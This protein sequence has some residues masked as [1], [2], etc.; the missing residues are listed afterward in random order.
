MKLSD[1]VTAERRQCLLVTIY[2]CAPN[3]Y[4]PA[5]TSYKVSFSASASSMVPKWHWIC[6]GSA[7][8]RVPENW[9]VY[10]KCSWNCLERFRHYINRMSTTFCAYSPAW[11]KA[12]SIQDRYGL[13]QRMQFTDHVQL[14]TTPTSAHVVNVRDSGLYSV[15]RGVHNWVCHLEDNDCDIFLIVHNSRCVLRVALAHLLLPVLAA[16]ADCACWPQ[17]TN[18]LWKRCIQTNYIHVSQRHSS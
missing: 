13:L 8:F 15:V 3:I 6:C 7:G 4:R 2:L 14:R 1:H 12:R 16:H 17:Q 18:Q 5:S 10:Y 9:G 11:R